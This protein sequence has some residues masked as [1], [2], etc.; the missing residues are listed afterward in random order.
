[1]AVS[2][3]GTVENTV[4]DDTDT[5]L[6]SIAG[7]VSIGEGGIASYTISLTEPAGTAVTAHLT[8]SGTASNGVDFSGS[9]SITIPA[10]AS[11]ASLDIPIADDLLIEGPEHFTVTLASVSG[12]NFEGLSIDESAQ[13]ITTAI[14]DNDIAPVANAVTASGSE[15]PATP[16][17]ITLTGTDAD[18]TVASFRLATLPA[19]GT[20]YLDAAKTLA[21]VA[22]TDLPASGNALIL[23]FQ[24]N[25]DWNGSTAFDFTAKD[26]TGLVSN[27]ATATL[28]VAA[29]NDAPAGQADAYAATEGTTVIRGSILA[30]DSDIDS[31]HSS[32]YAAQFAASP[33]GPALTAN[34]SNSIT[35]ALGGTVTLRADGTFDYVAPARNHADA[36][37]DADSFVYRVSDG[38]AQSEWTTVTINIA[39][40][41]PTAHPDSDS[42]GVGL[43]TPT[44]DNLATV[45]GN[46]IT[47]AG[48]TGGQ[49]ELG[50]DAARVS[51]IVFN[52]T[53]YALGPGNTTIV[54]PNG[55]LVINETGNYSYTSAY[56]NKAVAPSPGGTAATIADWNNAGIAM[57][58]FDGTTPLANGGNTLTLSALTP[59]ATGIVRYRNL[60]GSNNDGL[61]VETAAGNDNTTRIE[62]NEH[63]VLDIGMPSRSASVTLTNLTASESAQWRAYDAGGALVA[64]GTIT[65]NAS[66]I[67]TGTLAS[68]TAFRY[69]VF[70]G[71]ASANFRVNGLTAT[72]DLSNL[73]P[74]Q[75]TYTLTDIDGSSS[76]T[77]LTV[78]IDN[79]PVAAADAATVY[80]SGLASGTQ[81]GVLA[82]VA[83]GNLLANDAGIST[84]TTITSING[85]T[86]SGG[87]ITVSNAVGT[88]VVNATTG[89]YTYTLNGAATEGLNDNPVFNYVLTDS[90]T[91]QT[92]NANLTINIVD[93]APIGG[94]IAHTLQAASGTLT[95]NLVLV[96]D[97]SG[98]M[99]MDA[100][101]R[102]S[103][104]AG[105]DPNTVRMNIA[106]DALAKLIERFDMLGNVNVQIVDFASDVN[107]S[108]W[109][110]DNTHGAVAYI[111]GLQP[112]GGTQYSTALN[113]VMAGF[114]PP[115]A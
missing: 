105:F 26:N 114:T 41:A 62:S 56:Q 103:H 84:S 87:T 66:S 3:T 44:L 48:G 11:S 71:S 115:P 40:S 30:N 72:P 47:G 52:G 82:T 81:A 21:V 27:S 37:P 89:A 19:N 33:G 49:D 93:D 63:L 86:P 111:D 65:G 108:A 28:N 13:S 17:A 101:G 57:Y 113:A 45:T 95:Y 68:A 70:S 77:T 38:S 8:Y 80:E 94:D 1:E 14:I 110:V 85:V 4:V 35:T 75:F 83:T 78:S 61:G 96:V 51:S 74:D 97:R 10:G 55:T 100:D 58:G 9:A 24:P 22:G 12:G 32:L 18:G 99:A 107:E 43:R 64:S 36:T 5:T 2:T 73:T 69:L 88:L 25:A 67:A 29:V 76:T 60:S 42:V 59:A 102:W 98:S 92:T 50:A 106:K 91:G 6:V 34:G 23:Y 109:F 104:Q 46:V 53:T 31:P 54:T 15:D 90:V 16:I 112:G 79:A 39:D 7:P 20:L